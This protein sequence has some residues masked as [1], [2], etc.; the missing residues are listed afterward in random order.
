MV[1]S[2]WLKQA[3]FT[4]IPV[5]FNSLRYCFH[6][7]LTSL[8]DALSIE[9]IILYRTIARYRVHGS[10]SKA[11]FQSN[12]TNES[13]CNK[14][15]KSNDTA[16]P[17]TNLRPNDLFNIPTDDLEIQ[18]AS[19]SQKKLVNFEKGMLFRFHCH[20]TVQKMQLVLR[21]NAICVDCDVLRVALE[22]LHLSIEGDV[23]QPKILRFCIARLMALGSDSII[24]ATDPVDNMD[25]F[26][27]IDAEFPSAFINRDVMA[28]SG[29]FQK[30]SNAIELEGKMG[31]VIVTF[32][33]R[34]LKGI[35]NI[36]GDLGET[37]RPVSVLQ[38]NYIQERFL[39]IAF[40]VINCKNFTKNSNELEKAFVWNLFLSF[41]GMDIEIPVSKNHLSDA[42]HRT[43][44]NGRFFHNSQD[45]A[46][47]HFTFE[48]AELTSGSFLRLD[49]V[50]QRWGI[51]ASYSTSSGIHS[52]RFRQQTMQLGSFVSKFPKDLYRHFVSQNCPLSYFFSVKTDSKIGLFLH[53]RRTFG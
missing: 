25:L 10:S 7:A 27:A 4:Y 52:P 46:S 47:L 31:K 21:D 39:R 44:T 38:D 20:L 14:K 11:N 6:T 9:Q 2:H 36:L 3:I 35:M 45:A 53:F 29:L 49:D 15:T 37:F 24:L 30:V 12:A 16:I 26:L 42:G 32:E 28:A 41:H 13:L 18:L 33:E 5:T 50:M 8:E 1:G 17:R 43:C 22:G 48:R 40:T 51:D 34:K 23:G 19:F